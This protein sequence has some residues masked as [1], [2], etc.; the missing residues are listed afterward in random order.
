MGE[1]TSTVQKKSKRK[2]KQFCTLHYKTQPGKFIIH[3]CTGITSYQ[4]TLKRK[5]R[6][7]LVPALLDFVLVLISTNTAIEFFLNSQTL[8]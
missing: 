2:T 1:H 3:L 7:S 4:T 8:I 6:K 5:P